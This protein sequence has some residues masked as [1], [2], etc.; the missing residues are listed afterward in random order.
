[1]PARRDA[2]MFLEQ[3]V[4]ARAQ[5]V[6]VSLGHGAAQAAH[7]CV[8]KAQSRSHQPTIERHAGCQWLR[9]ASRSSSGLRTQATAL[10]ESTELDSATGRTGRV[11]KHTHNRSVT[12]GSD[13]AATLHGVGRNSKELFDGTGSQSMTCFYH[14]EGVVLKPTPNVLT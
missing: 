13:H 9:Q 8:G 6:Q 4:A 7:C 11:V 14:Y 10:P 3:L 12:L 1:M 5:A 2:H